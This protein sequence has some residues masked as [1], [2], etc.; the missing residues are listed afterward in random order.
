[1]ALVELDNERALLDKLKAGDHFAF[2]EIYDTY[3]KPLL[4]AAWNHAK[5][6]ELAEDIVHEVFMK[7][8]ANRTSQEINNIPAFLHTAIKFAVFNHYRKEK[9]RQHLFA[10]FIAEEKFEADGSELDR[11]FFEEYLNSILNK[12]PE[13]CQ[14]TFK[15]KRIEG[16]KNREI[17]ELL[18]ISEKG[19]EANLTRALKL[20]RKHIERDGLLMIL[21]VE[22][23][24]DLLNVGH[25]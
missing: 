12:I 5:D 11:L 6:K 4:A 8:W 1:M 21:S 16:F 18:Q 25:K 23:L 20:I 7:L 3:W 24:N 14:L 13:K 17:A 19:V 22:I 10:E 2:A 15:L 9:T